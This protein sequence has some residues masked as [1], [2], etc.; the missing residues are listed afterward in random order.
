MPLTFDAIQALHLAGTVSIP[1]PFPEPGWISLDALTSSKGR[2]RADEDVVRVEHVHS[3]R[4]VISRR[5][6]ID[7]VQVMHLADDPKNPRELRDRWCV[8][9][10]GLS[11]WLDGLR[12]SRP[13]P[14]LGTVFVRETTPVLMQVEVSMTAAEAAEYYPPVIRERSDA[15]YA[16]PEAGPYPGACYGC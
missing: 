1:N 9:R 16:I 2:K 6:R 5:V 14:L 7:D 4:L 8:G 10:S 11:I 13:R 12:K 15:Y 3:N